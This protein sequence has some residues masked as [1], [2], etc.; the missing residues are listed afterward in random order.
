MK[1]RCWMIIFLSIDFVFILKVIRHFSRFAFHQTSSSSSPKSV[2]T[3]A[4]TRNCN[5]SL[6]G[7]SGKKNSCVWVNSSNVCATQR[8]SRESRKKHFFGFLFQTKFAQKRA[9]KKCSLV[10]AFPSNDSCPMRCYTQAQ[11]SQTS[12]LSYFGL[13]QEQ[14]KRTVRLC[15]DGD[16]WNFKCVQHKKT[17]NCWVLGLKPTQL[18]DWGAVRKAWNASLSDIDYNVSNASLAHT[19]EGHF[20]DRKRREGVG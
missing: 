17:W 13:K 5:K 7:L 18:R 3:S 8:G 14:T 2:S 15:N 1:C 10:N 20:N 11:Q 19:F 4:T 9:A 12:A 16:K 6:N